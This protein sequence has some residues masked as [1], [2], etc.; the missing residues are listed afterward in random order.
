MVAANAIGLFALWMKLWAFPLVLFTVG[1]CHAIII[2]L[3]TYWETWE[4]R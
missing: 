1:L 4:K 3:G 2:V